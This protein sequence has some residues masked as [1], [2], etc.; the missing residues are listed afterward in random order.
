VNEKNFDS[1]KMQHGVYVK[2]NNNTLFIKVNVQDLKKLKII[3][4]K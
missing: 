3:E 4:G 2:K 1:I